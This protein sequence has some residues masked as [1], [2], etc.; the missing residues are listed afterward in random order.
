MYISDVNKS[1]CSCSHSEISKFHLHE[2]K[3]SAHA[4]ISFCG[5][6]RF[7][8]LATALWGRGS[9]AFIV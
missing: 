3:A 7:A 2:D 6:S 1:F 4:G 8:V 9:F 5:V